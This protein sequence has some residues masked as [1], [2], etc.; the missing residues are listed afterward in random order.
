MVWDGEREDSGHT[1]GRVSLSPIKTRGKRIPQREWNTNAF[2][3]GWIFKK[4]GQECPARA[5]LLSVV[6]ATE[7]ES[8]MNEERVEG[9]GGQKRK[10]FQKEGKG[11][12]VREWKENKANCQGQ[13][14]MHL[15]P[16]W[17]KCPQRPC[18]QPFPLWVGRFVGVTSTVI[19]R[20]AECRCSALSS[21]THSS[22][23]LTST[24]VHHLNVHNT[25]KKNSFHC[26]G[27]CICYLFNKLDW[28]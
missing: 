10:W 1:Q 18:A 8:P 17:L 15:C 3:W 9:V 12:G 13:A 21:H 2:T 24:F 16:W 26:Q 14:E 7:G 19:I 5:R 27:P 6:M 28:S 4:K 22:W 25:C 20:L 11:V 23:G